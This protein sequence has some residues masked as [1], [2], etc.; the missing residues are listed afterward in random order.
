MEFVHLLEKQLQHP[1]TLIYVF[2]QSSGKYLENRKGWKLQYREEF[3]IIHGL[4]VA[5]G[6][7]RYS[8]WE[9]TPVR[10]ID[11]EASSENYL[12]PEPLGFI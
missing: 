9:Y 4:Q 3:Y 10:V 6:V 1:I 8:I 7:R 11:A 2:D 5:G 12:V